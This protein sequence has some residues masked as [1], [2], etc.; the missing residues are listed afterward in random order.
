MSRSG[1]QSSGPRLVALLAAVAVPL[2]A[3]GGGLTF[4]QA[5]DATGEP[6]ALHFQ[7][8]F[9]AHGGEHRLEVWR[10]GDRR[11]KR[12]TDE[13][14]ETYAFHRP[15][16]AEYELSV[17]DLRKRIHTRV[18]RTNLFRI[19]SFTEWFDLTHGLRHPRGPYRVVSARAP[20]GTPGPVEA[21]RWYDLTQADRTTHVC[22]S[23]A[24]RIPMLIVADGGETVWKVTRVDRGPIAPGTF[25]I[26]DEGFV[27]NDA[28]EDIA[29]D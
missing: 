27:R 1:R 25:E 10:D 9:R 6:T 19:G 23:V 22:W 21:C 2:L 18:D 24:E 26:H 29:G 4:E 7:A 8:A 3:S 17:L 14:I 28:N 20:R 12:R 5:F 16:D 13:T 15:G 11:V